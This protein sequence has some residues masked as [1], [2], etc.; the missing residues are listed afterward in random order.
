MEI[1]KYNIF[2]IFMK[3]NK[4][5]SQKLVKKDS[6]NILESNKIIDIDKELLS[7][8]SDKDDSLYLLESNIIKNKANINK[9]SCKIYPI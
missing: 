8:T 5:I 4:I 3:E 1:Y 6:L 2:R 9:F 7:K